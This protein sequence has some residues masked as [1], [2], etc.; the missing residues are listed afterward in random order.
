MSL[1]DSEMF[2]ELDSINGWLFSQ[3]Y[4]F[5][6]IN[7]LFVCSDLYL[8]LLFSTSIFLFYLIDLD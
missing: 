6:K 1:M 2:Q 7:L 5:N 8:M 3:K 4:L